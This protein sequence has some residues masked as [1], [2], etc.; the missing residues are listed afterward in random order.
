MAAA[1]T[2]VEKALPDDAPM[3]TEFAIGLG[4]SI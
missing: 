2:V 4:L 1:T 3:G